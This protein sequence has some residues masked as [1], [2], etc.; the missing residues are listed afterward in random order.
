MEKIS[1]NVPT[2]AA[3]FPT[4]QDLADILGRTDFHSDYFDVWDFSRLPD[5][6]DFQIPGFPDSRPSAGMPR[7]QLA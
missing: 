3:V 5:F 6:L 1:K 7:G 4:N 2:G